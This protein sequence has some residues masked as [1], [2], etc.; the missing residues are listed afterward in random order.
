MSKSL[1]PSESNI[2]LEM[3]GYMLKNATF[4]QK[5][6]I[7]K[8]LTFRPDV[9]LDYGIPH[10]FKAFNIQGNDIRL[11]RVW[12]IKTFGVPSKIS[13]KKGRDIDVNLK[14]GFTLDTRRCQDKAVNAIK[15][16]FSIPI[17]EGGGSGIL[18][19]PCGAGKTVIICY[20]IGAVLKRKSLVVVHTKQL[21]TQWEER[22]TE[23]LPGIRIGHVQGGITE[24]D[25]CDV[26]IGMLQT[27][28]M[29]ELSPA[30]FEDIDCMFIDECHIANTQTFS[31][32]LT[33]YRMNYTIGLSATPNRKDK[34]ERVIRCHLGDI[35]FSAE[36]ESV[37]VEVDVVYTDT[38]NYKEMRNQK[39][40]VDQV[41]MITMLV[42]DHK[43]NKLI[44]EIAIKNMKD[45]VLLLSDRREHLSDLQSMII[46]MG[47][48]AESIGIY[49]G[50]MKKDELAK[51]EKCD[52][53]LGTYSIASIGLDIKGLNVLILATPRSEVTQSSGRILRDKTGV[54]K[55]IF[56]VTD[57][58]S[59]FSGQYQKRLRCYRKQKFNINSSSSES[60]S[61]NTIGCYSFSDDL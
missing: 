47:V 57:K 55:R 19:L 41:S 37:H 52:I 50:G 2:I 10:S 54:T 5:Q 26:I 28:S 13:Y 33:K 6:L 32:V 42:T 25:N 15:E 14:D 20:V 36:R 39:N 8:Q 61:N 12:G 59:V 51:S 27:L 1:R 45:K 49:R 38:S 23:F 21:A 22:L 3:G 56:D 30:L 53:I 18:Q 43:R 7:E 40:K 58:F 17:E 11:P 9:C 46:G 29:K 4:E 24:V 44:S 31:S 48:D 16:R 34:L 35:L 60:V